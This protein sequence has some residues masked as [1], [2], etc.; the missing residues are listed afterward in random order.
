MWGDRRSDGVEPPTEPLPG[1][2]Q[3]YAW[4]SAIRRDV[5]QQTPGRMEAADP[6]ADYGDI[7]VIGRFRGW[8]R[9]RL[10]GRDRELNRQLGGMGARAGSPEEAGGSRAKPGRRHAPQERAARE[11]TRI[12]SSAECVRCT[13]S[14]HGVLVYVS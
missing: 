12:P 1:L 6:T 2:E 8:L 14:I 11:G 13:L 5:L 7:E 10:W 4:R 3:R 9:G